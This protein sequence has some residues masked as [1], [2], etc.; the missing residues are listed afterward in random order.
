[1]QPLVARHPL[2][3]LTPRAFGIALLVALAA[4]CGSDSTAPSAPTKVDGAAVAV[5]DGTAHTFVLEQGDTP[6]SVGIELSADALAG[7]PDTVSEWQL[8]M[9]ANV[10]VPPW[11]HAT[12]DWNPQGHEPAQIYGV[13]HFDFHFY[14]IPLSEQMAIAGGPDTT[15]VPAANVPQDYAS[16]VFA[17]PMMGVH[18]ADTLAAEFH[19]HPFDHTFIYGFY[20][21]EMV[22]VEPMVTKAY[23]ES[24]P[25]ASAPVKQ[26]EAFQTAGLYPRSYG[27]RY[28]SESDSYRLTLDSLTTH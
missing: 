7:L 19:G 23:L 22:F 16:Q 17:V 15:T 14:D 18:W 4:G 25:D 6:V 10:A 5:G 20:H 8:Q 3:H 21:G 28:D 11:D 1:M 9:P 26:P 12:L 27:V 13:P 24:H 2:G